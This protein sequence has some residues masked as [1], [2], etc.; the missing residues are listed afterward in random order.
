MN[1]SQ[2]QNKE[3]SIF[4]KSKL[5]THWSTKGHC[6]KQ[7]KCN[8]AHGET[9]LRHIPQEYLTHPQPNNSSSFSINNEGQTNMAVIQ[10]N[11]IQGQL[12]NPFWKTK[13]CNFYL[14][15]KCRNI[16]DCNYA[17][18][19]DELRDTTSQA[20]QSIQNILKLQD[21]VYR[22]QLLNYNAQFQRN[23]LERAKTIFDQIRKMELIHKNNNDIQDMLEIA[24]LLVFQKEIEQ[25]TLKI[26]EIMSLVDLTLDEREQHQEIKSKIKE[27]FEIPQIQ[28]PT[29]CQYPPEDIEK[30][31]Q[32]MEQEQGQRLPIPMIPT[33]KPF[34]N[35][36]QIYQDR[37]R[38]QK[39][40]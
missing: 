40:T 4:Y 14:Q 29:T 20:C 23:L 21:P 28:F 13:I 33:I 10:Q 22:L 2:E 39:L 26:I 5:C 25:A 18:V 36:Q 34:P 37:C 1:F 17:H 8:Y 3:T 12:L 24:K 35:H 15:G 9:E 11:S 7:E 31:K 19:E 38:N 6:A 16:I 32:L 27:S 30:V